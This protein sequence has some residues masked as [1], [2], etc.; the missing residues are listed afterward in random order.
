MKTGI[1][2]DLDFGYMQDARSKKVHTLPHFS[3][4]VI[5]KLAETGKDGDGRDLDVKADLRLHVGRM[6]KRFNAPDDDGLKA[7]IVRDYALDSYG[8]YKEMEARSINVKRA[9][10]EKFMS[11]VNNTPLFPMFLATSFIE[12]RL[13]A[14]LLD[15]MSYADVQIDRLTGGRSELG[16][17]GIG[18]VH[19]GPAGGSLE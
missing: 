4:L 10:G 16:D 15:L 18:Y 13:S 3:D 7:A 9:T 1:I 11:V 12:G 8:F 19:P 6:L 2:K 14:G 5:G 17:L